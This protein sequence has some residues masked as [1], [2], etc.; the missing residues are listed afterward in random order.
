MKGNEQEEVEGRKLGYGERRDCLG[1]DDTFWWSS[2]LTRPPRHSGS[3]SQGHQR[4][5]GS[6]GGH[7]GLMYMDSLTSLMLK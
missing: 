5:Q 3:T 4:S 7:L 1:H 2:V 6:N